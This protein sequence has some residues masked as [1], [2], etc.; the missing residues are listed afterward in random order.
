MILLSL[1]LFRV[2]CTVYQI[3]MYMRLDSKSNLFYRDYSFL[4]IVIIAVIKRLFFTNVLPY[5]FSAYS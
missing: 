2:R 5:V 3:N 4:M 1:L